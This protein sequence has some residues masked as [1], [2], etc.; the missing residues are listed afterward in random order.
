MTKVRFTTSTG[1]ILESGQSTHVNETEQVFTFD[2]ST[3]QLIGLWSTYDTIEIR[4]LGAIGIDLEYAALRPF[5]SSI[6]IA[7]W[8]F[9][10]ANQTVLTSAVILGVMLMAIC[11][12]CGVGYI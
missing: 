10:I 9:S 5:D 2:G 7:N 8:G 11:A 6:E 12:T 4:A 3:F 1:N